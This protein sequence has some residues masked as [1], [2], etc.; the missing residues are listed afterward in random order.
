M[1]DDD[2]WW[3]GGIIYQIYPRSFMDASGDGVGDLA[4]IT[5]KL[6]YV[7]GLG[8]DAIWVSPFFTS[9][10]KDFGYDISD[11]RGVDPLFGCLDDF[12]V[13]L[14][15]AHSLGLK[16]MIDQVLSHSSDQH[17]WFEESRQS[18]DNPKADWYVWADPKS[19]GT[20]PN[21]WLSLFGGASWAWDSRRR[22]YYQRNF[23]ESQPDLNFHN[24]EVRKAQLDNVKFWLDLGVDGFRLDV[25]NFTFHSQG[26]EDNPE[27]ADG[28]SRTI[29]A[30]EDM[31]H[32]YQKHLYDITQPE[33]LEFLRE[34]RAL[35]NRYPGRAAVGE[36]SG[37]NQSG[38]MGQYT[39]GGDKLHMAYNFALLRRRSG[40]AYIRQVIRET[41]EQIDDGW[42]CW[43][44]S[45]HDVR[46]CLTRWG[47]NEDQRAFPRIALAMLLSLRGSV[48]VYQGEELGL[49][50]IDV[51]FD[52]VQDPLGL[53]FWPKYKGRDGCRTPMVWT[54]AEKAGF[55][56]AEPWLPIHKAH[57]ELA[58]EVQQKSS[59]STLEAVRRLIAWRR[60]Q[61]ALW[62]GSIEVVDEEGDMLCWVR[63]HPKQ[64]LFVA[65]NMT[66]ETLRC[67]FSFAVKR[68][69][70]GHGFS[71]KLEGE[72]IVLGPYQA[73][74]AD[75]H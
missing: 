22:Q 53:P 67:G 41:E 65:L 28:E 4:G 37:N 75:I 73:W 55:T 56:K 5:T 10:M 32:S 3:K 9:P 61:P 17:P 2:Q 16:V 23:L 40:P 54:A 62:E 52:A 35:L 26:L 58:V 13:M 69:H 42:P 25:I 34:L 18:R 48:C 11:Y 47:K 7:A 31:P 36:I 68:I 27:I 63:C 14:K 24:P 72:D 30:S 19:D 51:P 33:N 12:V 74:F 15:K 20:P 50:D 57:R 64:K 46:R 39:R 59:Q 44:L 71:G 43:S 66:G 1:N 21:N 49:P 38:I 45:N 70:D 60:R 6:D 29:Q 8:V